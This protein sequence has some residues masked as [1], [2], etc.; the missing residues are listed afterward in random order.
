MEKSTDVGGTV[1]TGGTA[2]DVP[3]LRVVQQLI[4]HP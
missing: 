1:G 2:V 3:S 4:Y